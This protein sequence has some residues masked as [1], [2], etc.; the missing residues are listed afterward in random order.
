ML[1]DLV[2][3]GDVRYVGFCDAPAWVTSQAQ[4]IALLTEW[5]PIT[6]FQLEYSLLERTVEAEYLPMTEHL[7]IGVPP[8]G[9]AED[10]L[11]VG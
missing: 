4:T 3:A 5:A 1:D 6:P 8:R 7:G 10:G 11:A 2:T 9:P